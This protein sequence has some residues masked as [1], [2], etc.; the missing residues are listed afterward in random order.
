MANF[1]KIPLSSRLQ[2]KPFIARIDDQK[3]QDF[4]QLIKLSPVG[5]AVFENTSAGRLYGMQRDWLVKAK[6]HWETEFDWCVKFCKCND[7]LSC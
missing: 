6:N 5:P 3:L 2:P 7:L 1:A 4:K